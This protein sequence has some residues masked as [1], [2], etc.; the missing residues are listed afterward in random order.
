MLQTMDSLAIFS[1]GSHWSILYLVYEYTQ[2]DKGVCQ[3]FLG[4]MSEVGVTTP[5]SRKY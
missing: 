2:S 5:G 4:G 3:V 1:C